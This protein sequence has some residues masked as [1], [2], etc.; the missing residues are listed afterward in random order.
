MPNYAY[1]LLRNTPES[2][3]EIF[4]D[5]T[6][7]VESDRSLG[8]YG[9]SQKYHLIKAPP[10]KH[11]LHTKALVSEQKSGNNICITEI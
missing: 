8:T 3:V 4:E 11:L 5:W 10:R 9:K 1:R 7:T 6:G 2:V